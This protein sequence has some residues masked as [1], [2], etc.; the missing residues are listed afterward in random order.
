[1]NPNT[2]NDKLKPKFYKIYILIHVYLMNSECCLCIIDSKRKA[3][4]KAIFS[5]F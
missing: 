1:M 2:Q 5:T 4:Y 3:C